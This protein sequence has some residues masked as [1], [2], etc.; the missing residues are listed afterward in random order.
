MKMTTHITLSV[1]DMTR[2]PISLNSENKN[3]NTDQIG[4]IDREKML[5]PMVN[6]K[7]KT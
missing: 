1:R 7:L 6:L 4:L 2:F 3:S 5:K